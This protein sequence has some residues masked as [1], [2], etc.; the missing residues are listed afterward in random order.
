MF[1]RFVESLRGLIFMEPK[2]RELVNRYKLNYRISDELEITEEM[3]LQHWDLEKKLT[4]ELW[5]STPESR[6]EVFDRA[7]TRLYSE[8]EW[9]NKLPEDTRSPAKKYQTWR[10]TIG[11]IR[12]QKIYEIGSGKG[13]MISYLAECGFNCKGTEITRE[14]GSKHVNDPSSNLSWSSS[15][16]I[17][18]E[19]FEPA[20]YYDLVLSNQVIEHFH[21]D[22]LQAHFQNAYQIL[23]ENGRY[24]FST[25]HCHGGPHDVSYVF[26]YDDSQGMHLKEYTYH[27]LVAPLTLAGFKNISYAIPSTIKKILFKFGINKQEQITK[28][29][30]LYFKLMLIV[31]KI[32]FL[33]PIKKIRRPVAKL[34]KKLYIFTDNIFLIAQK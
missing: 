1:D 30:N 20:N 23:N 27:E 32:L 13:T 8:L 31:E 3:I 16:G 9:L 15:D 7:Y 11:D 25:P 22:D 21:P 18:L 17:N 26:N 29:G 4:K 2:G 5:E 10:Q 33:I 28:A 24:I 34:L 19:R 12:P 14:R 6:W